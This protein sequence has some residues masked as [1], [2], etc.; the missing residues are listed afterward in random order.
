[1]KE[2]II[3]RKAKVGDEKS[4]ADMITEGLKKKFWLYNGMNKV[5][6]KKKI[7]KIRENYKNW[8]DG[9]F[10]FLAV[11][12]KTKKIIG[13]VSGS[14]MVSGRLRHRIDCGWGVHPDYAGQGIAME[15]LSTLLN[16]AKKK[17]FKRAEA[18]CAIENVPSW[19]LAKKCGF[20][21][22]GTKKKAL[23]TDDGRYIDTYILGKVLK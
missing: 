12:K 3:I 21:I 11:D 13:S 9:N 8:G 6:D 19:K 10:Y 1:M 2:G 20:E 7:A 23:L 17:G 4:F 16:Y 14:F 22:E 5:P 15:L 18:E